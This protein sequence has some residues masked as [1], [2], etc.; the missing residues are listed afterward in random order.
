MD[1]LLKLLNNVTTIQLGNGYYITYRERSNGLGGFRPA[2][3]T[4][5]HDEKNIHR[6]ITDMDGAF[7]NY[8][9]HEKGEWEEKL[10]MLFV[11]KTRFVIYVS[12]FVDDVCRFSWMVQPDGMYWMDE[13]GYGMTDEDEIWLY[14]L[15]NEAGEFITPFFDKHNKR[16]NK[17]WERIMANGK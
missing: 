2:N 5:H 7:L 1:D 16:Y 9:G 13:D 17:Q 8:P 3:I 14:A 6:E 15:M 12:K 4:F 10:T 11:P